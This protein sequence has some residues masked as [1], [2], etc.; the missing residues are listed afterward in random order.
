MYI[1]ENVNISRA[2][3]NIL[4]EIVEKYFDELK[5]I[6]IGILD[7]HIFNYDETNLSD[8]SDCTK[9]LFVVV[10]AYYTIFPLKLKKL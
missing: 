6:I 7:V 4:N 10:S 8:D 9:I 5:I 2:R 3:V 1:T